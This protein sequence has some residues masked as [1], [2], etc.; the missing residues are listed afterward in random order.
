M[1]SKKL[2][3]N[4]ALFLANLFRLPVAALAV[5]CLLMVHATYYFST[6]CGRSAFARTNWLRENNGPVL[7]GRSEFIIETVHEYGREAAAIIWAYFI[8]KALFNLLF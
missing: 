5:L 1:K 3:A 2:K 6:E 8:L 4:V 7:Q